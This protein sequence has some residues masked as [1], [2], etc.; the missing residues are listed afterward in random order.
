MMII[1]TIISNHHSHP[2]VITI[3]IITNM[4]SPGLLDSWEIPPECMH[5]MTFFAVLQK[6]VEQRGLLPGFWNNVTVDKGDL[7]LPGSIGLYDWFTPSPTS[8]E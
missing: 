1:I 2:T 6:R 4:H 8:K 5:K 3:I 7:F